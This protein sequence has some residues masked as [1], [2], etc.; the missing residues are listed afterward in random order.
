MKKYLYSIKDIVAEE[1]GPIFTANNDDVAKRSFSFVLAT[2]SISQEELSL[3]RLASFD[4][5]SG[6]VASCLKE[7]CN[8]KDV[9]PS[10]PK[11]H[12]S[13]ALDPVTALESLRGAEN[14]QDIK[15][16]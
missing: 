10:V 11:D 12:F 13:E 6:D 14:G 2:A 8:G 5:T 16:D 7:V 15:Q 1:F 3:F 4:E 9:E